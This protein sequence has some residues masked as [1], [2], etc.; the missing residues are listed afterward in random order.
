VTTTPLQALTQL[1]DKFVEHYAER[2]AE[3]LKREAEGDAAAQVRRAFALAFSRQPSADEAE[4]AQKF[5]ADRGLAQFC[6]VLLN[7]SEFLYV[8]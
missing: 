7:A 3:R 2:F 1:N 5:V 6:I 4:Y 8:D